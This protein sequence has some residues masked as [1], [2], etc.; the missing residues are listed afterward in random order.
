SKLNRVNDLSFTDIESYSKLQDSKIEE[1]LKDEH[2]RALAI[3]DKTS[4]FTL[5]LSVSLSIISAS[6]SSVV[7]IL[8]ESQFNEIISF[9]FGV[10]SLYMLS[11]G[12]IALG[13]LKTLP[14]Y[15]YGTAFEISKCTHVLIRSLLSQE[16]VNEIRYVRNELAFISLRNGFLIIF[17][18]LLLCIVVLFQQICICRQGW[19]TGLQCS[20]LG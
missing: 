4:K 7:K 8:P 3:D 18:A 1:R 20:G 11:G 13:A 19:V 12:L 5:G 9:L 15:G 2:D 14:K 6:A 17:I 10:S 16:K